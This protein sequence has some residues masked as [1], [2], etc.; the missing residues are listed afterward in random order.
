MA[1]TTEPLAVRHEATARRASAAGLFLAFVLL[2]AAFVAVGQLIVH[3]LAHG[4]L[5][6]EDR[7]VERSLAHDRTATWNSVTHVTTWLAETPTI[8]GLTALVAI[9]GRLVWRRWHDSLFVVVAVAGE[10]LAFLTVTLFVHRPR[11]AVVHLDPAPPTSSFPSGHTAAAVAFYG[12]LAVLCSARLRQWVVRAALWA[13]AVAVPVAV[14]VS[15]MY[16]GMHFPTD[17]A[18]G[19]LLGATWLIVSAL[20]IGPRAAGGRGELR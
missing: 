15:R 4:A 18:A 10:T 1:T 5:G 12:A 3:V 8:I 14:A 13:L 11:P 19:A 20:M 2:V 17:V 9:G 16:R 6:V 7:A